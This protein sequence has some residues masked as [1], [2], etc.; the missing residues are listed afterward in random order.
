MV[1]PMNDLNKKDKIV[2]P[3]SV[4]GYLQDSILSK[5]HGITQVSSIRCELSSR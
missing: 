2:Y 1:R 5:S 3:K 4:L